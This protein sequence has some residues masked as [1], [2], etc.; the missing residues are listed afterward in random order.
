MHEEFTDNGFLLFV[1]LEKMKFSEHETT[2]MTLSILS[3]VF[4]GNALNKPTS[5]REKFTDNIFLLFVC[6]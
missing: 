6:F 5:A 4:W 3:N 2:E 1:A